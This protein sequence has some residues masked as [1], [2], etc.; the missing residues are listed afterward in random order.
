MS[1]TNIQKKEKHKNKY[2]PKGE[3]CEKEKKGSAQV[4]NLLEHGSNIIFVVVR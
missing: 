4:G 3:S 1:Q 2:E